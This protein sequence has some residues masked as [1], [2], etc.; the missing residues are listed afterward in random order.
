MKIK[1]PLKEFPFEHFVNITQNIYAAY[2][3][4]K[5][6]ITVKL[7]QIVAHL[8]FY[9]YNFVYGCKLAPFL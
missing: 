5:S 4:F 2:K 6:N 8:F 7:M 9:G 3:L 1:L